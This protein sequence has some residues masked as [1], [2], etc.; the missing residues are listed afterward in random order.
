MHDNHE[1]MQKG[2]PPREIS[3]FSYQGCCEEKGVNIKATLNAII[4]LK[5]IRRKVDKYRS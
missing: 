5:L 2:M 4:I 3:V 1:M